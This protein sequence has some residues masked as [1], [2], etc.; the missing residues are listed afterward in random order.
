VRGRVLV[1]GEDTRS[2]LSV[3]RSL[4]RSGLAVD[5]GWCAL[6]APSLHSRYLRRLQP[7]PPY[8][9]DDK[10]WLAG[11]VELLERE[12]Y[13]LVIPVH[14]S[15]IL[16]L[17]CHRREI[18]RAG[19]VYLLPDEVFRICFSKRETHELAER[20]GIPVPL[21]ALVHSLAEAAALAEQWGFPLVL[22]PQASISLENPGAK[23]YVTKVW[24]T[25][26]LAAEL[27]ELDTAEGLL[28]E[29]NF[30]GKGVGVEVLCREGEILTAFQHER[31]HEPL[32]GGGSSY[33]KSVPLEAGLLEAARRL[34]R[35]LAY[36]GVAML[37]FKR[38]AETGRSVLLEINARFWGSLP[39]SLAAGMDF[40]RYLY[41][42]LCLG[43][44][45]FPSRYRHGV[46]ARNWL[47][48]LFWLRANL[49]ADRTNRALMTLTP[50]EIAGELL[51][52]LALRE[53]S[54]TFV[55]D[56][57]GPAIA[58]L[59]QFGRLWLAGRLRRIPA[60]RRRMRR[61]AAARIAQAR[62]VLF[63]CKGNVCRSPFAERCLEQS[64]KSRFEAGSAGFYPV[65]GRRPPG[66]AIE[67][68][69]R[70][71]IDLGGHRSRV[72]EPEMAAEADVILI[73]DRDQREGF[74]ARY[75][76]FLRKVHW[77]GA[78]D[79]SGPLAIEDPYG[80]GVEAFVETYHRVQELVGRV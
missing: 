25:A 54:D 62:R 75:P 65:A 55:L 27:A 45:E 22:K 19:R 36:S 79:P 5:G 2:F 21:Q 17:Q 63:V 31:V 53:R 76:E 68:A 38:N 16:P 12:K 71:G 32:L 44:R 50:R 60:V 69:A 13:D 33:R 24:G 73:F 77:L 10:R 80:N 59:G 47:N 56:D 66:A 3:V 4:G 46:Y 30:L 15:S 9:A 26:D 74:E 52:V 37:E 51:N 23:R 70:L 20:L 58:E 61:A 28:V 67:A 49:R 7:L 40:P 34:M 11:L 42:M 78:L 18:E 14:D 48:D 64:A 35:A 29:E 43:R 57:P 72:L 6:N 8:R 1:L 41:E 39:L